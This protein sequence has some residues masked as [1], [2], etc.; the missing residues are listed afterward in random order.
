MNTDELR[1][2]INNLPN[3][4]KQEDLVRLAKNVVELHGNIKSLVML[5]ESIETRL[6]VLEGV[7]DEPK[8]ILPVSG[9]V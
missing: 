6:S 9:A 8:L 3:Y 5:F 1:T 2:A 4:A 7:N